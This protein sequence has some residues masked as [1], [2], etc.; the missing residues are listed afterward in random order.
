MEMRTVN[1]IALFHTGDLI[2]NWNS[3][4]RSNETFPHESQWRPYRKI[5]GEFPELTLNNYIE[6]LDNHDY[7]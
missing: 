2:D 3:D 5:R 1:P 6:I 7:W 4:R